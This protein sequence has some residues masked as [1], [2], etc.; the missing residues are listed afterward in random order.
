[1]NILLL[2]FYVHAGREGGMEGGWAGGREGEKER[3]RYVLFSRSSFSCVFIDLLSRT[4]EFGKANVLLSLPSC[5][6]FSLP[7]SLPPP[8][9][10]S[11][12]PSL[13]HLLARVVWYIYAQTS[14]FIG[15]YL[16]IV[17]TKT[18]ICL[19]IIHP[20]CVA[21]ICTQQVVW[22]IY[23]HNTCMWIRTCL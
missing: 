15:S 17:N 22:H 4:R 3:E 2:R 8:L 16:Y 6:S 7:P 12:P 19:F 1:M 5:L 23:A 14:V 21:Y 13:P 20:G 18:Y 11:L 10:P 9:P